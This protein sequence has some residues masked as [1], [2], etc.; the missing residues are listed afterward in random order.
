MKLERMGKSITDEQS[1]GKRKASSPDISDHG[2]AK[3]LCKSPSVSTPSVSSPSTKDIESE[4]SSPSMM[5][6]TRRPSNASDIR[7][8]FPPPPPP[9]PSPQVSTTLTDLLL[10][11]TANL[12]KIQQEYNESIQA[13]Q[14]ARE[15]HARA[16]KRMAEARQQV[17]ETARRMIDEG[18]M[19]TP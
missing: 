3:R 2:D 9:P 10:H 7:S 8:P 12:R 19:S 4:A 6:I 15:R 17:N 11:Q 1:K 14:H 5:S 16:A 18:P 13:V